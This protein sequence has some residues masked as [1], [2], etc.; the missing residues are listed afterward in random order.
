MCIATISPSRK[1]N[2]ARGHGR[3]KAINAQLRDAIAAVDVAQKNLGRMLD[4]YADEDDG[5]T[6]KEVHAM[7]RHVLATLLDATTP[8]EDVPGVFVALAGHA[9]QKESNPPY[10]EAVELALV[11]ADY[12]LSQALQIAG[13]SADCIDSAW[14]P[15]FA[16]YCFVKSISAIV[17]GQLIPFD[18]VAAKR[19][20]AARAESIEAGSRLDLA[21]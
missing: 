19:S 13:Q 7:T 16:A 9:N 17:S 3:A 18:R 21:A 2:V 14:E 15:I 20:L 10:L 12:S 4:E 1:Q 5:F 11:Y 6:I 8:H